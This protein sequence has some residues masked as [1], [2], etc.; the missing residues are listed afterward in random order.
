M[1]FRY[2]NSHICRIDW[3][4]GASSSNK[5]AEELAFHISSEFALLN[6]VILYLSADSEGITLRRLFLAD[7]VVGRRRRLCT[8]REEFS[9]TRCEISLY[10]AEGTHILLV[11][12]MWT[13]GLD[14]LKATLLGEGPKLLGVRPVYRRFHHLLSAFSR[15]GIAFG[16]RSINVIN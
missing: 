2:F 13:L 6:R 9:C 10:I 14:D 7:G 12:G 5:Y 16:H 11:E 8:I 3:V 4:R 1:I 15:E